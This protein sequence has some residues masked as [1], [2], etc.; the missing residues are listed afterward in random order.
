METWYNFSGAGLASEDES[1]RIAAR[2]AVR[3]ALDVKAGEKVLI[4][5]NPAHDAALISMA[6]YDAAAEAGGR[7]VLVFQPYKSQMDFAED[8]LIAAFEASPEV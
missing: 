7:P 5:G 2:I 6:L 1:L 4:I 8:V 3:D